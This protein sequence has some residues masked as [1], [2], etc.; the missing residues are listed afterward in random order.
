MSECPAPMTNPF[1]AIFAV[2]EHLPC[3]Y[4]GT[5]TALIEKGRV[6]GIRHYDSCPLYDPLTRFDNGPQ[7]HGDN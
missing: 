2:A 5:D 7:L 4:C 1:S 3:K 6:L